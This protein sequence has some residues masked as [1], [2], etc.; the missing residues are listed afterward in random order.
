MGLSIGGKLSRTDRGGSRSFRTP[1]IASTFGDTD[2]EIFG[3]IVFQPKN[4]S[5]EN[6]SAENFFGRKIFG[7]KT[8]RPKKISGENFSAENFAVRIAEG[9]SKGG[10]PGEAAAPAGPSDEILTTWRCLKTST[11]KN[12]D[13][14]LHELTNSCV[15][16]DVQKQVV[17][18]RRKNFLSLEY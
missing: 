10:S 12:L 4:F 16:Q 9:G 5:A 18:V 13:T 15:Q 7:R 3:R 6:F 11:Y 17:I 14:P 2:G 1:P 8:F